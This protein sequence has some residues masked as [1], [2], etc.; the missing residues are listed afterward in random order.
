MHEAVI[1][2]LSSVGRLKNADGQDVK[3]LQ[4]EMCD[5]SLVIPVPD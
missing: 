2:A 5:G 4:A 3:L 1:K